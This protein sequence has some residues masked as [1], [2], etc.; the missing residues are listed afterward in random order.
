MSN[1]GVLDLEAIVMDMNVLTSS[2]LSTAG[3]TQLLLL[4]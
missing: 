2:S 1:T 3:E 4:C